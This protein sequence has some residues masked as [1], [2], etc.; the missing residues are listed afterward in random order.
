MRLTPTCYYDP[1]PA[2]HDT[3]CSRC[4]RLIMYTHIALDGGTEIALGG[5]C[6]KAL[7]RTGEI[8]SRLPRNGRFDWKMSD[9]RERAYWT[10]YGS[11]ISHAD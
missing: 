8:E 11:S 3:R 9:V 1:E 6:V 10:W 4:G 7:R 2:E 5:E